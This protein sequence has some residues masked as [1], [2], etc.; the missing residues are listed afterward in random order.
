MFFLT[1]NWNPDI[2]IDIFGFTIR[3]YSMMW[4]LAFVGGIYIMG[5]IFKREQ[6]DQKYLDS[7]FFYIFLSTILGARLGHVM[8]YQP[9]LFREDFLNV[10]LPFKFKGG[11]E[12]TGFQG[13]ASHGA[14]IGIIIGVFLYHKKH[15]LKTPLWIFDRIIIPIAIGGAFV[16]IGNFINSEI[17][18]KP[19]GDFGLGVRF[20]RNSDDFN[21]YEAMQATG[22]KNP[23]LAY[24]AITDNPKFA[25]ILEQIPYRHPAQLYEA[26]G[27]VLLFLVLWLIYTKTQKSEK[28]GYIFG[29]FLILLWA[30]RFV[31]EF[32]KEP[33]GDEFINWTGLNTG[34]WLSIPFIL[35]GLFLMFVYKSKVTDEA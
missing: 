8:F 22:L 9:E 11:F 35:M 24:A 12:F 10:F 14:A 7:L 15:K 30:I 1:F 16:R 25:A 28:Q 23:D 18:G 3:Y 6:V 32:F 2:G 27:Y 29:L 34:Q 4:L 13:L 21:K 20:V 31:V 19:S 17:V 5:K 26:F 33:Q